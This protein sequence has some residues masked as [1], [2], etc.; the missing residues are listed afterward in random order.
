[1]ATR[2]DNQ[3]YLLNSAGNRLDSAHGNDN[4]SVQARWNLILEEWKKNHPKEATGPRDGT[5]IMEV[6]Q[7]DCQWTIAEGAG[8]DPTRT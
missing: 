2:V 1:M 4:A 5:V 6:E 3:G 7:G 8:A